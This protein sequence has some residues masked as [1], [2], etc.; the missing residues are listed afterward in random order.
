M[1]RRLADRGRGLRLPEKIARS[2]TEAELPTLDRPCAS[3]FTAGSAE[4]VRAA[5]LGELQELLDRRGRRRSRA[6]VAQLGGAPRGAEGRRCRGP[7]GPPQAARAEASAA[8]PATWARYDERANGRGPHGG[9]VAPD[10]PRRARLGDGRRSGSAAD[11][12]SP[13]RGAVT[14]RRDADSKGCTTTARVTRRQRPSPPRGHVGGAAAAELGVDPPAGEDAGLLAGGRRRGS[15]VLY[16][17]SL[18]AEIR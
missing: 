8:R 13:S 18:N 6:A 15:I 9:H 3:P 16:H 2:L 14:A 1:S 5:T 17:S 10:G 12:T 4:T 11:E 7:S